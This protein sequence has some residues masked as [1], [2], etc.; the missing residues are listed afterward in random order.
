ML[1]QL[2]GQIRAAVSMDED[3]FGKVKGLIK[4][5]VQRL[6]KEASEEASHKAF[7][8]KETSENEAKRNKL[9]AE[10]NKLSTRIEK[11]TADVATLKQQVSELNAAL[12]NIA[13][14]QQ[15]M[16][17]LRAKEHEEFVKAHADFQQGVE[18]IRSALKIL[19][20]YY[21][22]AEGASFIQQQP[23]TSTHAASTDSATGIISILEIAE[24]DFS[25]SVAEAQATEEDAVD[26][27]EKTTQENQ[28][29]TATKRAA[30]EGK[31]QEAARL[32][33]AIAD[34]SS[35]CEGVHTELS[36]VMEYL[37]KLRPQCTTEPE[38]Y[39]DRKARREKEIEGLKDALNILENETAFVQ[40]D[41]PT[42]R[43]AF[44][45][46]GQLAIA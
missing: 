26:I 2:A 27:Y 13:N 44:L 14:S 42:S 16:D 4:D 30:V 11:A 20:E 32:E 23:T 37:E 36:A 46:R 35:D 38:S 39:E 21:Q 22:T 17:L 31:T 8:D 24:S 6:L 7:C 9:Q 15:T 25:R 34:A 45:A 43:S 28:V 19:R 10:E 41:K 1:V 18:G 3:P 5:M 12:A 29:S 40:G 33:K